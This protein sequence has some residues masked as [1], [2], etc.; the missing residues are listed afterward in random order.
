MKFRKGINT[1]HN[2]IVRGEV[3]LLGAKPPKGTYNLLVFQKEYLASPR[4]SENDCEQTKLW[5]TEEKMH[6]QPIYSFSVTVRAPIA[7][8]RLQSVK[9]MNNMDANKQIL[10]IKNCRVKHPLTTVCQL[11]ILYPRKVLIVTVISVA[12]FLHQIQPQIL[13]PQSLW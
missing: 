11:K 1:Y 2:I 6:T 10:K 7:I 4:P 9:M 3:L 8:A 12:I 5:Q 13:I